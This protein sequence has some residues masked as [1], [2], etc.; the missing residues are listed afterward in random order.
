M[1]IEIDY[2]L[3]LDGKKM[4]EKFSSTI[5][6]QDVDSYP[7]GRDNLINKIS[8]KEEKHFPNGTVTGHY[9]YIDKE[10]VPV[11]VR[12]YA[13]D[14][15]Y[16]VELKSMKVL[17]G[18]IDQDNTHLEKQQ[19]S[20]NLWPPLDSSTDFSQDYPNT[21]NN[22]TNTTKNKFL[23]LNDLTKG[24]KSLYPK[25]AYKNSPDYEIYL[26][27]EVHAPKCGQNK[28]RIYI[29]KGKR[30]SREASNVATYKYFD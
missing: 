8:I 14:T 11:H 24:D 22:P 26:Q 15:G 5:T 10:G 17:D 4:T 13:D 23:S 2:F 28:V 30:K 19:K 3:G 21:I 1:S 20:D 18:S 25:K 6:N 29:D 27:N 7:L 16:G 12:Y 9:K